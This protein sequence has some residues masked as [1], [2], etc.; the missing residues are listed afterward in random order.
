[1][2]HGDNIYFLSDRADGERFNLFVYETAGGKTRQLTHFTD[3]DIKYPS[4]GDKAIAFENAGYIYLFDLATEKADKVSIRIREDFAAGRTKLTDVSKNISAYEISRDGQRALL[5]PAATCSPSLPRTARPAML[6]TRSGVHEP[7]PEMVARRQV[8]RVYLRCVGRG[9]NSRYPGRRRQGRADHQQRRAVQVQ[10]RWSP[11]SKKILW[12]DKHMRLFYVDVASKQVKQI[13]QSKTWEIRDYVWSPDSHW[14]AY[15]RL[16]RRACTRSI[17][18]LW[19]RT[20]SFA[21]T[22][23]WYESVRPAFSGDGKYL[24]FVSERDFTPTFSDTEWNHVYV[25]MERIYLVTLSK[26]TPSPLKHRG[27]DGEKKK[28]E[29][30]AEKKA[31]TVKIDIDGIADRVLQLPVKPGVYR[32]LESVGSTIYYIRSSQKGDKP[33]LHLFDLAAH[34]DTSLGPI[35]GFE[36]STDGKKMLVGKDDK[37]HLIDLPKAPLKLD[38]ALDL[39]GMQVQ[40]NRHDEW[41]QIFFESWRQMRDYF[42]DPGMNGV[43]WKAVREKYRP[44]VEYVNHRADL[45][46]IIGEMI[47]ELDAGHAYVGGG[48]LPKVPRIPL[49]LLGAELEREPGAGYYKITKILKGSTWDKG[50]RS[51]LA[52]LGVDVKE[53]E[54]IVAVNDQPTNEMANIYE[55]LV[56]TAGKEVR[57]SHPG[58][59]PMQGRREVTVVPIADEHPL[60][61]HR[62]VQ[63]NIKKVSDA[64]GGKVGYVHVPDMLA[65]G[66]NQFAKYYYPQLRKQALIIDVRGNGGGNVSPMLIERLRREI[67]MVDISRDTQPRPDPYA[68]MMGPKVCL[69]NE[70]SA[71][72]GDLFPYRFRHA[73]LGKLI[74]KRSWGGVIGIRGTL[75]FVDG[76]SLN[77]P[78]FSR[79]DLAGKKWIIENHGVDPDIV[80]ENDPWTEYRGTD[81]QLDRAIAVIL[82]QLRQGAPKLPPRPPFPKR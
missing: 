41:R 1:M 78:E 53:G 43:D 20:K 79:Y 47:S 51:P 2:W 4:L 49:G 69:L 22:K 37:Y 27:D 6:Q 9:R 17:C 62:W 3:F 15:A 24:F 80:V 40:L 81:Q 35:D 52:E 58:P 33:A 61:Y 46:Y 12:A 60:Y 42:Y 67:A 68:I 10:L 54:L 45:T 64:T 50:L 19:S 25:D 70:Y 34:K 8:D 29:K 66:L 18:I 38:A 23:G 5:Q 82:E 73:K 71:S 21:V 59:P 36:I 7:Q 11:D 32:N 63:G 55:A 56:N 48:D 16:S 39:S 44:L 72:D 74:G 28:D 75:P 30:K 76:G 65:H 57:L 26:D 14:V 13:D 31:P 77:K